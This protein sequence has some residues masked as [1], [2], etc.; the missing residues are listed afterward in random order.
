MRG[1]QA[2]PGYLFHRQIGEEGGVAAS[3]GE[4]QPHTRVSLDATN[5]EK[6]LR[7][8]KE[9]VEKDRVAAILG[10]ANGGKALAFIPCLQEKHVPGMILTASAATPPP[11]FREEEKNRIFR[12]TLPDAEAVRLQE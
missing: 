6:A 2:A 12:A 5:P 3:P 4:T 8:V 11:L 1:G 10:P 7:N 9:L